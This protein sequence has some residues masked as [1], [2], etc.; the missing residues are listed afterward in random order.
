MSLGSFEIGGC[1]PAGYEEDCISLAI[2]AMDDGEDGPR[3][4]CTAMR[5]ICSELIID[6][7]INDNQLGRLAD[8]YGS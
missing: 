7:I 3:R 2:Q 4:S 1:W 6:D 5:A 8:K